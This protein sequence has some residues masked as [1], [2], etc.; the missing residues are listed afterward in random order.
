MIVLLDI[1]GAIIAG[2]MVIITIVNSIFN[3]QQMNYNIQTLL[4]LNT[5]GNEITEFIDLT[6][7]ESVGRNLKST[8]QIISTAKENEFTFFTKPS[9][10][11]TVLLNIRLQLF[12][13]A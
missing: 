5:V 4:S 12:K 10:A 13:I 9:Y 6:Y 11:D 8:D 1:I 3:I 2:T 7:L